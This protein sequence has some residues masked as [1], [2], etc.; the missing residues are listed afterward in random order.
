MLIEFK[1]PALELFCNG[2][3]EC[4]ANSALCEADIKLAWL[5]RLPREE[6][7]APTARTTVPPKALVASQAERI[8]ICPRGPVGVVAR[9]ESGNQKGGD[10]ACPLRTRRQQERPWWPD[11]SG[12]FRSIR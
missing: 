8:T 11:R 12:F 10:G 1:D 3:S 2:F 4:P 7:T 9:L 5:S 6:C